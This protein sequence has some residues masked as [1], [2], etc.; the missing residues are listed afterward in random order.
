MTPFTDDVDLTSA[1]QRAYTDAARAQ[2]FKGFET[3]N[4]EYEDDGQHASA[5]RR[6]RAQ[7]RVEQDDGGL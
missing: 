4:V 2:Q 5:R 7:A 3:V 1:D 6:R